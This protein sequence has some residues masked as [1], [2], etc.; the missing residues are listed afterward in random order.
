[1]GGIFFFFVFR[2]LILAE[3]FA[4]QGAS[5]VLLAAGIVDTGGKFGTGINVTSG[6][7]GKIYR[8]CL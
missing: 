1:L 8:R 6:T 4:A 2:F 5:P 3:I 7:G